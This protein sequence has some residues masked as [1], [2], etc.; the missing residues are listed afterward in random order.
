[1]AHQQFSVTAVAPAPPSA[2]WAL[3]DDS[4]SWPRWTPIDA[5]EILEPAV[6]A[7]PGELR[8]VRNGRH[9]IRERIVERRPL[10]RL[11]YTV[12][13]GLAVRDYRAVIS[14][15]PA[16]ADQGTRIHWETTFAAKLPGVGPIYRRTLEKAT[17]EFMEGLVAAAGGG[18]AA[19]SGG[20]I[21][22]GA[23]A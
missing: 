3:L 14:V 17:N 5:V 6:G 12:E 2:V 1:M 22:T 21:G 13:S 9:K 18:P 16:Q 10:Q 15:A 4:A 7:A 20:D 8:L 23:R 19:A 11:A